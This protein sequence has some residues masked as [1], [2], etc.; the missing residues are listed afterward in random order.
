MNRICDENSIKIAYTSHIL[1][2][3]RLA[4]MTGF[5]IHRYPQNGLNDISPSGTALASTERNLS[6]PTTDPPKVDE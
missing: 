6:A 1:A 4:A 5:L 2:R 3:G